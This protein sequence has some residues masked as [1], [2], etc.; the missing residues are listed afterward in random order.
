[1]P[2]Q[3]TDITTA[4]RE[5]AASKA[6][7]LFGSL[8]DALAAAGK[9]D[10]S[11]LR[12]SRLDAPAPLLTPPPV[13]TKRSPDVVDLEEV[14]SGDKNAKAE[15]IDAAPSHPTAQE[16]AKTARGPVDA[17]PSPN[18]MATNSDRHVEFE[19]PPTTGVVKNRGGHKGASSS[20]I[21][22]PQ[23]ENTAQ[24][25]LVRG[26]ADVKRGSFEKDP[27]VGWLVVVGGPG[28]GNFRPIFEGNNTVGRD[29]SQRVAI[30]FGD[31]AISS[32]EQAFIRYD[33]AE[34]NFLFVPNLSKTNIV[35]VNEK[36]PTGAVALHSMDVITIGRTQL[37]FVPFCGQDFDWS[38]LP[39]S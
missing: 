21:S 7:R 24:T 3:I 8:R 16:A 17:M 35:S 10:Q 20:T 34:R 32:K 27:V 2:D 30:D 39:Q 33:S 28:L 37:V 23:G 4:G 6:G 18:V 5:A 14:P 31:D 36:R 12:S 29:P 9:A 26:R 15:A 25:Q 11:D 13:P 22:G 1:M 19:T 38:E